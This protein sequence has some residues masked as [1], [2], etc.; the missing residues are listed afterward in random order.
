MFAEALQSSPDLVEEYN[1]LKRLHD[2]GDMAIYRA[3]KDAFVER[4]LV[5]QGHTVLA[6]D[7]FDCG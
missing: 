7:D 4:V 2:G 1:A 5:R 6:P 3:A